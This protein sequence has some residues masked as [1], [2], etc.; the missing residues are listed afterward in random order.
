M[1]QQQQQ[2]QQNIH[3]KGFYMVSRKQYKTPINPSNLFKN[4]KR[5]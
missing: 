4:I 1:Q 3:L 5:K 2:Q